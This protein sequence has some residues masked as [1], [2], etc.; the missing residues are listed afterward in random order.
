MVLVAGST[1]ILLRGAQ[2][3]SR[4]NNIMTALNITVLFSVVGCSLWSQSATLDNL[5]PYFAPEQPF[6]SLMAG[7]GLVFFAF[8]G[9]DMVASLSEEGKFLVKFEVALREL[10]EIL[11]FRLR[12]RMTFHTTRCL[13]L[14]LLVL[15]LALF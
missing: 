15:L 8:I 11:V 6:A 5:T 10:F 13:T 14:T 3:S 4:F 2:D 1:V 9:F 7:A 12:S